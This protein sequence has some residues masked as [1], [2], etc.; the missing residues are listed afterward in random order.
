[1]KFA[2]ETSANS[3]A[4]RRPVCYSP[5]TGNG[6]VFNLSTFFFRA[7]GNSIRCLLLEFQQYKDSTERRG[8]KGQIVGKVWGG[9][10]LDVRGLVCLLP[11]DTACHIKMLARSDLALL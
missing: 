5:M 2:A 6:N 9:G 1:M 10:R 4:A 8:R 3:L 7:V 11:D